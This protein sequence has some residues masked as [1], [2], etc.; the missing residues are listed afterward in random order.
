MG[1][2]T[3]TKTGG[4]ISKVL[5]KHGQICRKIII[6]KRFLT[7]IQVKKIGMAAEKDYFKVSLHSLEKKIQKK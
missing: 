7:F 5:G 2:S 6:D 4:S 3:S 1:S